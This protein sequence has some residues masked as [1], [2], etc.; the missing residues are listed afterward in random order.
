MQSLDADLQPQVNL[1]GSWMF[2]MNHLVSPCMRLLQSLVRRF[3]WLCHADNCHAAFISGPFR[4]GTCNAEEASGT[5]LEGADLQQW[6][7][8]QAVI[9]DLGF[10]E[11]E[12]DKILRKAFGW[13]GQGFW[14]KSKVKEVPAQEQVGSS[15]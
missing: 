2:G 15:S 13:A 5:E 11:E 7:E 8:C 1:L 12:A 3:S 14:R 10:E 9:K 6:E 4:A